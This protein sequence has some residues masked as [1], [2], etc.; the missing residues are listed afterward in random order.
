MRQALVPLLIIVAF[1]VAGL[2]GWQWWSARQQQAALVAEVGRLRDSQRQALDES[3]RVLAQVRMEQE[4]LGQALSDARESLAATGDAA[5]VFMRDD[6]TV[7]ASLRVAVA[8][9]YAAMGRMP[10]T[11]AEAGLPAPDQYRGKSLRSAT[12]QADGSI[13]LVFD[14]KSGVDGGR[15]VFL[16]DTSHAEAMGLQWHCRTSD[17]PLIGQVVPGCEYVPAAATP[18]VAAPGAARPATAMPDDAVPAV[19]APRKP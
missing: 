6:L 10:V 5:S 2:A 18:A 7:S 9:Y 19:T 12:L 11:H 13:E 1:V 14:A 16:P 3:S 17:Y 8:E 4:R 15:V